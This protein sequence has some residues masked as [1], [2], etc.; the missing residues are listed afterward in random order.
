VSRLSRSTKSND[1]R[2]LSLL[3][4]EAGDADAPDPC[5]RHHGRTPASAP[6]IDTRRYMSCWAGVRRAWALVY[7][8]RMPLNTDSSEAEIAEHTGLDAVDV[9]DPR[10]KYCV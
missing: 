8:R 2:Q 9:A 10:A 6:P 3:S 5:D 4:D 1:D 7:P